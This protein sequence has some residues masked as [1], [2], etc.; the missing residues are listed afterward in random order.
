MLNNW[1]T[2]DKIINVGLYPSCTNTNARCVMD[3]DVKHKT[4]KLER[5]N[6]RN[7]WKPGS[8]HG[9]LDIRKKNIQF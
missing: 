5:K 2:M 4:I 3:L 8:R 9:V 7:I 1:T 6:R